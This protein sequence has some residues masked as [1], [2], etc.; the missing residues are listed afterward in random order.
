ML[1][2]LSAKKALH[3]YENFWQGGFPTTTYHGHYQQAQKELW[4]IEGQAFMNE[5][6]V[7]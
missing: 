4:S 7:V 6:V 2:V 5:L 1:Q 3:I